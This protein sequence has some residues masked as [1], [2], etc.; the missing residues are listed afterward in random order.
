MACGPVRGADS[1]WRGSFGPGMEVAEPHQAAF[2]RNAAFGR[3]FAHVLLGR[4]DA[5]G[6][7]TEHTTCP[8]RRS[9]SGR[10]LRQL[11]LFLDKLRELAKGD[12]VLYCKRLS[13]GRFRL[14]KVAEG[15][16]RVEIDG[17]ALAM[18]LDG[19]DVRF[20]ARPEAWRPLA[21]AASR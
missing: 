13:Q 12:L 19:I 20:V 1:P 7:S 17:T 3:S 21:R 18:L 9:S 4:L 11:D 10:P 5:T 16:T 15:A 14:P 6:T 2:G 8:V